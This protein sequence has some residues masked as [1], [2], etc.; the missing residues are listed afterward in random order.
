MPIFLFCNVVARA[1][2]P[3]G[4]ANAGIVHR[5]DEKVFDKLTYTIRQDAL[6]EQLHAPE[7]AQVDEMQQLTAVHGLDG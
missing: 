4:L 5:H 7:K 1:P 3:H 6:T 2:Q